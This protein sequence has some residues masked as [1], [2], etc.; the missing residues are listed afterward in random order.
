MSRVILGDSA[1]RPSN[2]LDEAAA[3]PQQGGVDMAGRPSL[4][5]IV[6][7]KIG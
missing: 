2:E 6:T 5:E 4:S 1:S 3:L 7:G